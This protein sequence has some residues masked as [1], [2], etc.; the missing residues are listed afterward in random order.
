MK[1]VLN[2]KMSNGN[3]S[4]QTF[5]PLSFCLYF[6]LIGR[7]TVHAL[8][9]AAGEPNSLISQQSS[10]RGRSM[11]EVVWVRRGLLWVQYDTVRSRVHRKRLICCDHL[12]VSFKILIQYMEKNILNLSK[13][14][15]KAR[16]G[17]F[18]CWKILL[19]E[20]DSVS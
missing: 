4:K 2:G 8:H 3:I 18:P 6:S 7:K 1:Y 10:R 9:T 16:C 19:E 17:L 12:F 11:Q 13:R 14:G 5:L 15:F 20:F